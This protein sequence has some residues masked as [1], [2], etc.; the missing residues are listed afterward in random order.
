MKIR[1]TEIID[2]N[3]IHGLAD[4]KDEKAAEI[5]SL[6]LQYFGVE[7]SFETTETRLDAIALLLKRHIIESARHQL[8][9]NK[10]I[11]ANNESATDSAEFD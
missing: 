9:V 10:L 4:I 3:P 5:T 8:R 11:V 1:V 6:Y 7:D 2:I